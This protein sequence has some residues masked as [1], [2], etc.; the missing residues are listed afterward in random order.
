[1]LTEDDIALF[2]LV[3]MSTAEGD[4]YLSHRVRVLT[5]DSWLYVNTL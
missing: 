3:S 1:M 4:D 5:D 2:P